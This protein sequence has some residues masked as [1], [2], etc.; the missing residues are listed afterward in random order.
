M[1]KIIDDMSSLLAGARARL[2]DG[3]VQT[4]EAPAS[5]PNGTRRYGAVLER[6]VVDII[7]LGELDDPVPVPTGQQPELSEPRG[8]D[9]D[10]PHRAAGVGTTTQRPDRSSMASRRR[11]QAVSA[12]SL[13]LD[14]GVGGTARERRGKV[15]GG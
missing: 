2:D 1:D 10:T 8:H 9:V 7:G 12:V 11:H 13:D 15:G 4:L 14:S 3:H 6:E 5:K